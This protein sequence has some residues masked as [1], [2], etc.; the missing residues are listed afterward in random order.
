[1]RIVPLY[2]R[3]FIV[4][5]S[6]FSFMAAATADELPQFGNAIGEREV[7]KLDASAPAGAKPVIR[8]LES[9]DTELLLEFELP[10][11]T[12]QEFEVD[13]QSFHSLEIAG[14]AYRGEVGEPMLPTFSQ[15]IQIPDYMGVSIEVTGS[16]TIELDG[17]KPMPMQP[18]DPQ[19]F[20]YTHEAYTDRGYEDLTP[21]MVGAPAIARDLRVVPITYSPV[22]Y[23]P[24]ENKIEVSSRITARIVFSGTDD[25][26]AAPRQNHIVPMSFHNL[27]QN[28][29]VNYTGPRDSQVLGLGS[30][31][32]ICQNNSTTINLLQPLVEWRTR[33]GYDV[34]LATTAETGSSN[35][36]IKSWIQDKYNTWENPPEYIVLIGDTS[37]TLDIAH[38]TEN[39]SGYHGETD[40]PYVQL[41]GGDILPDAHIGRISVTSYDQLELYVHKIVSYE[42]DPYMDETNW[43]QTGTVTGDPSSSGWT[44]VQCMQ[45]LRSQMMQNSYSTVHA[46]FDGSYGNLTLDWLDTGAT[47]FGYRGYWHMSG[48]DTGDISNLQNGRKMPFAVILTCDTGSFAGGFARSEAFMRGGAPP[49]I[50]TAGIAS[51]GTA[52]LGTHT[53]YNNCMTYGIWRSAFGEQQYEFGAMLSRGKYELYLNYNAHESNW[54]N[55][56]SSWNNLMGDPA[57]E[58]WTGVPQDLTVGF[59]SDIALGSNSVVVD[60]SDGGSPVAGAYVCLWKGAETHTGGYT[61]DLGRIELP[62][63][64]ATAGNMKLTVTAHNYKPLLDTIGVAQD[65]RFVGYLSH[66]LDGD[67]VASPNETLQL[68]V[69]VKNFGTMSAIS[70]AGF[71]TEA[72]G[73]AAVTDANDSY[74][75]I[76]ASNTAWGAGGYGLNIDPTAPNG[77]IIDIGLDTQSGADEWHSLIQLPIVAPEYE[78]QDETLYDFGTRIDPG[79]TGEIS[80]EIK[81][82]GGLNATGVTATLSTTSDWLSVT[83]PIG[84]FGN[85]N[86]GASVENTSNRFGLTVDGG[87]YPGH[88]ADM[89]LVFASADGMID[90]VAFQITVGL[91]SSSDPTGHDGYGYYAYDNTD[92]GYPEAPTYNWVEIAT[93]YGGPGTSVGLTDFG[94]W[95]DDTNSVSLPFAFT[96]YGEEFTRASICSNGWIAMG[97]TTLTNYRNWQIPCAGAPSHIIPVMW[98]NFKQDGDNLVYH[99]FD[100]ANHRYIIQWSRMKNLA[101]NSRSTFQVIFYDQEYYPTETGDGIIEMQFHTYNNHDSLQQ[102]STTGIQNGDNTD[103]LLYSYWNTPT[104]G[105]AQIVAGRAIRFQAREVGLSDAPLIERD[106]ASIM[107]HQNRPN[108]FSAGATSTQIRFDLGETAKVSLK[109]YD[110]AGRLVRTLADHSMTPG[111]H[112]VNWDGSDGT[113]RQVSSGV[114]YYIL[115]TG[116]VNQ[117]RQ[118]LVLR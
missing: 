67:G 78:Y 17:Y 100:A 39:Y 11:I 13:G 102:Y 3:I 118:M 14:G 91:V 16:E 92:V 22:R 2:T 83:D 104:P 63:D 60:V 33:R 113:G 36:S 48:I 90:T 103:G 93:N 56:F 18:G 112:L 85:A 76:V 75:T 23:N 26:N 28:I 25:R 55:I 45:W 98:D 53:R 12:I 87:C 109:I 82:I 10:E 31:V 30:Y 4:F 62:V 88:V 71:I 57:G 68:Q 43:Y 77:H 46:I 35:S 5:V 51:I 19:S 66:T 99:W 95:Q 20:A 27:Y 52:T 37:G 110:T 81:N 29:V 32:I 111:S 96:Y 73:Y 79:E 47:V 117:S 40:H 61:D 58:L 105:S 80:V 42:S 44:T 97:S 70:V 1:M 64:I 94:S 49:N 24:N 7:I 89:V 9:S 8:V 74:G 6:F 72:S 41:A 54:V 84:D 38:W 50:P 106:L 15:L 59:P 101:D 65:D 21:T 108:P 69:Q 34:T 115:D 114:Y 107:L 86:I 116:A